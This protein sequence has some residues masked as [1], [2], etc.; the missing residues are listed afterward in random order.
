MARLTQKDANR[1]RVGIC[2]LLLAVLQ[3]V[4]F[5]DIWTPD[6]L[7]GDRGTAVSTTVSVS[8]GIVF[9]RTDRFQ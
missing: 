5:H 7:F 2:L 1:I 6:L 3:V 9:L 8:P 4:L